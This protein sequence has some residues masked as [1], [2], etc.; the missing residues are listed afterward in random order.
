MKIK[1]SKIKKLIKQQRKGYLRNAIIE[2]NLDALPNLS[3]FKNK[4]WVEM[5][6]QRGVMLMNSNPQSL[7]IIKFKPRNL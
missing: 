5:I 3:F 1:R 6:Y 2:I 7:R 4:Y